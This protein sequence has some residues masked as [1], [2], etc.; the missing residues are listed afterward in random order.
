MEMAMELNNN[1]NDNNNTQVAQPKFKNKKK[2]IILSSIYSRSIITRTISLPITAI[3]NNLKQV[4]EEY[5]S[6]HYE[7]KCVVEG[8]IKHQST[9]IIT[10]SSGT[11]K[12]GN[13]VSFDVVFECQVCFP[14]EGTNISCIAK[15]NTKAGITAESADEKPS[16]I[17]VFIARD[18]HYYSSQFNDVKEGDK[19]NIRVIG[20]RF[21]LNDKFV[22]IIGQLVREQKPKLVIEG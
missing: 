7:G 13:F 15:T 19:I 17:I 14:V 4:I 8:F 21:E 12:R 10:Y 1:N 20:Q 22:S 11:I 5:I 2:E 16:P 9:K 3:G 18:H 6:F